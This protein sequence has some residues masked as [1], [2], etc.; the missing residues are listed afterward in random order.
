M[1]ILHHYEATSDVRTAYLKRRRAETG[2]IESVV[3]IA[4]LVVV[5]IVDCIASV[6]GIVAALFVEVADTV[7]VVVEC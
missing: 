1:A 3:D 4:A 7:F 6:V 5:G 2:D